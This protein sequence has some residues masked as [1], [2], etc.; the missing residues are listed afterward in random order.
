MRTVC[1]N[2]VR[3]LIQS[4]MYVKALICVG[5]SILNP[6]PA[7][8][9]ENNTNLLN[10]YRAWRIERNRAL[11]GKKILNTVDTST[12]G[13]SNPIAKKERSGTDQS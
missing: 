9:F 1:H 4:W 10:I 12:A 5:H 3:V 8:I 11:K 7:P 13:H 2:K 6:F